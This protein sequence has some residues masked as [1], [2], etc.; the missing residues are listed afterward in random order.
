MHGGGEVAPLDGVEAVAR[1]REQGRE[2]A[3]AGG[4]E[5]DGEAR[6]CG[7]RAPE[8]TSDREASEDDEQVEGHGPAADPGGNGP[9]DAGVEAGEDEQPGRS[10]G[11]HGETREGE[12]A[13]G[14]QHEHGGGVGEGADGQERVERSDEANAGH[15][16]GSGDGA[17]AEEAQQQA[18][19]GGAGV[20][21]VPGDEG[22]EGPEGAGE[23]D[24]GAGADE[25]DL[26]VGGVAGVAQ[27]VAH[28][29]A[30]A[31]G[32]KH[33]PFGDPG[34]AEDRQDH[35]EEGDGVEH[36]GH[37]D[38]QDGDDQASEGGSGG[39][40]EV[41]AGGVERDGLGELVAGDQLG[42]DGLKG[43]GVEGGP[44]S[45]REGQR[46]EGE[47]GGVPG[48]RQEAQQEGREE[49]PGLG[50]QD[51]LAAV[52]DVGEG[53]GHEGEDEG[54]Q[55]GRGLDHG[56]QERGGREGGH[57]P[58]GSHA[59]HHGPEVRD[60]GR[61]PERAE[62]AVSQRIP[63]RIGGSGH[64]A[65]CGDRGHPASSLPPPAPGG[66]GRVETKNLR[67]AEGRCGLPGEPEIAPE[68]L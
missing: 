24:E 6:D 52:D 5:G 13:A 60:Q 35:G 18:V 11:Q 41:E 53:S 48:E 46:Q 63:D 19:A 44:G 3:E 55:V 57:E 58:G 30:H 23:E 51:Q 50:G 25:D 12:R 31:F 39:A 40:G 10:G 38:A 17:R 21:E 67:R 32:R 16:Q 4:G 15:C 20:E 28:G 33:A 2:H 27:A 8:G 37:A 36:E 29:R 47:G 64:G 56:D 14:G 68:V 65:S 7:E 45:Q 1:D 59:L 54:R 49:H 42:H 26:D 9:L 43:R 34:P 61:Q 62:G 66:K 22:H